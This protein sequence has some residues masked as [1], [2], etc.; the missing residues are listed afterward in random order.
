M[1]K[2]LFWLFKLMGNKMKNKLK[3]MIL[4]DSNNIVSIITFKSSNVKTGD[5][6]QV[7]ILRNDMDPVEAIKQNK[8]NL[9][10][11][12]WKKVDD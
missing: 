8:D 6:C 3:G 10:Q 11:P 1:A 7:W 12:L 9:H 2:K 4:N 5:M